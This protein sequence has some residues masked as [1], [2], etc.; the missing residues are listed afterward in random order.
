MAIKLPPV[1]TRHDLNTP[2]HFKWYMIFFFAPII[3]VA[4]ADFFK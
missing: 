1:I 4:I 3:V 2:Y